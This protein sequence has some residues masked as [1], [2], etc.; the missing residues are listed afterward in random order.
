MINETL[1]IRNK[2]F[3]LLQ[4][5]KQIEDKVETIQQVEIQDN[6]TKQLFDHVEPQI[7]PRVK[8]KLFQITQMILKPIK[9]KLE[10]VQEIPDYTDQK[11]FIQDKL[12][13][14]IYQF[15]QNINKITNRLQ[16][17]SPISSTTTPPSKKKSKTLR[18]VTPY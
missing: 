8:N 15:V 17:H 13:N 4:M 2:R 6:Y 11:R 18:D 12:L 5:I 10:T 3:V 14:T 9:R 7:L 16:K 1:T